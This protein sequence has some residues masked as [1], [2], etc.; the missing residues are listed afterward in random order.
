VRAYPILRAT[1]D[2]PI[3][4]ARMAPESFFSSQTTWDT[5]ERLKGSWRRIEASAVRAYHFLE[6]VAGV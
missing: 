5:Y 3:F 6:T 1:A 2:I 4:G